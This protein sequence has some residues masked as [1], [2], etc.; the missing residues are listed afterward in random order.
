MSSTIK[1]DDVTT[2]RRDMDVHR[3]LR[4]EWVNNIINGEVT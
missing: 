1:T 3:R 2:G 4:G